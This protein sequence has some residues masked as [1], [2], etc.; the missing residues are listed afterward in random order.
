MSA[1][2]VRWA[3]GGGVIGDISSTIGDG[4]PGL[5]VKRKGKGK[6]RRSC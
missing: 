1:V 2:T 4:C 3:W 5:Y 6:E